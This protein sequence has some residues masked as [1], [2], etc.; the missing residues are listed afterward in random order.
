MDGWRKSTY[1]DA[2]GGQCV[3]AAGGHGSVLV[4]D[5]ADR[6]GAT[7]TASAEAWQR[8]TDSLKSPPKL[9]GR[10][11]LHSPWLP[12]S[13]RRGAPV[14]NQQHPRPFPPA[15]VVRRRRL[16]RR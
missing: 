14:R 5:T 3:E 16:Q 15:R 12:P 2:N 4:R 8:F 6:D 11:G 1:S 9:T 7:L 10:H 13:A